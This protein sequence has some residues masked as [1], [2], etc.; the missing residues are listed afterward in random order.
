MSKMKKITSKD[1]TPI[2]VFRSGTGPP[3]ILVHG[4]LTDHNCWDQVLSMLKE[5]FTVYA[6]D[7]RGYGAS[8][9]VASY[10]IERE[11]DDIAAV[12]RSITEPVNLLAH[13][14]GAVCTLGAALLIENIHKLVL[15]EPPIQVGIQF[16]PPG[17][18]E[19]IQ[20]LVDAGDREGAVTI[21]ASEVL[22]MKPRELQRF[23]TL[24]AWQTC[25]ATVHSLPREM[26]GVEEYK[27]DA[28]RFRD[29]TTPTLL[30]LGEKSP[31]FFSK[32]IETIDAA[33]SNSQIV[34]MPGQDHAAMDT[35]P[36]L[37]V[38]EVV[39]FLVRNENHKNMVRIRGAGL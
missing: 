8:G 35:A 30:L 12:A 4:S 13:S 11:Y 22:R 7:R 6:I 20:S 2:A 32:T 9:D 19:R 18:I 26:V 17:S 21:F 37:F 36:E 25:V 39:R 29:F 23:R 16:Q 3:L 31:P 34:V 38:N 1:G 15:Y 28:D 5:N 10:S 27:F 14:Y 33:L 24:L